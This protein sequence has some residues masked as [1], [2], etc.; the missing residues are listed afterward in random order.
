[1]SDPL[2]GDNSTGCAHG[3]G[4]PTAFLSHMTHSVHP[5]GQSSL[6]TWSE[7]QACMQQ[8]PHA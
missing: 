7:T 5:M 2:L 4:S 8:T 6:Y 3:K 1:M